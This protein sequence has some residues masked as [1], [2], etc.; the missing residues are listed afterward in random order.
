MK[1]RSSLLLSKSRV[2]EF[3]LLILVQRVCHGPEP[4]LVLLHPSHVLFPPPVVVQVHEDWRMA[5]QANR[6]RINI[7]SI[8][9]YGL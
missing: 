3:L 8:E 4:A 9:E 1:V 2:H 7:E 6:S 5:G